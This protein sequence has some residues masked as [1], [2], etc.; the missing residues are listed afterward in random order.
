MGTLELNT[1]LLNKKR[2]TAGKLTEAGETFILE[3]DEDQGEQAVR[4]VLRA[5]WGDG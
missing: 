4:R 2:V 3:E 5:E 1:A